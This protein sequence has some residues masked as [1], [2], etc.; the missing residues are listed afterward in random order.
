MNSTSSSRSES[1]VA[2]SHEGLDLLD[3]RLWERARR[4]LRLL[5]NGGRLAPAV[6]QTPST[7]VGPLAVANTKI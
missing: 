2:A 1:P 6:A 7:G 3:S 4:N 5:Y